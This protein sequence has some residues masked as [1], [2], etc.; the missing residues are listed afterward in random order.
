[1]ATSTL[2]T[3]ADGVITLETLVLRHIIMQHLLAEHALGD[4]HAERDELTKAPEA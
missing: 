2:D 4:A 3:A 1:V